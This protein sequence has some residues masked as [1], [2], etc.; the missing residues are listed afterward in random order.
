MELKTILFYSIVVVFVTLAGTTIRK[1]TRRET[2]QKEKELTHTVLLSF[3]ASTMLFFIASK[4][5]K[6]DTTYFLHFI[7]AIVML[8]ILPATLYSA[9]VAAIAMS[10]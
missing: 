7:L 5:F 6:Q 2:V 8:I 4:Y 10:N 1:I 3:F 9:G